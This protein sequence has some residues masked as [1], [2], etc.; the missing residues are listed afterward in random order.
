MIFFMMSKNVSRKKECQNV[1]PLT[2][3][4]IKQKFNTNLVI[5]MATVRER[6]TNTGVRLEAKIN[7]N[8]Y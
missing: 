6:S 8:V 4:I 7:T 1:K 2:A 3:K 5:L